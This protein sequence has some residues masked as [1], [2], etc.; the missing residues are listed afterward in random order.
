MHNG[1][2]TWLGLCDYVD[3]PL[4]VDSLTLFQIGSI[5]ETFTATAVMRLVELGS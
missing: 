2:K 5:T 4:P 3:N 1:R